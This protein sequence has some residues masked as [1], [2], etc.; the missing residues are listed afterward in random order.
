MLRFLFS[1]AHGGTDGDVIRIQFDHA[2]GD[3]DMCLYSSCDSPPIACSGSITDDE[4]IPLDVVAAGEYRL[5]VFGYDGATNPSYSLSIQLGP[6]YTVCGVAGAHGDLDPSG[7]FAVPP[8]EDVPFTAYPDSGCEV[9]T[10]YL[11]PDGSPV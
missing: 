1:L 3:L 10:W 2:Q 5:Q 7:C 6:A 9:D 4:E 11:Y 8:G